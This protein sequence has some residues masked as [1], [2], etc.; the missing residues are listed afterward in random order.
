MLKDTREAHCDDAYIEIMRRSSFVLCP[1]GYGSSSYR[2]F[3]ALKMGR[4]PVVLSDAW[5]APIGPNWEACSIFVR[6]ANAEHIPDLL[7][8]LEKKAAAMGLAARRT[9]DEWFGP[10]VAFH[11]IVE[12]CLT[13]LKERRIPEGIARNG[14]QLM[15]ARRFIEKVSRAVS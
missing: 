8:G 15:R 10:N 9:W 6:E 1:R 13:L 5:I 11:R 2:L 12:W 14:V 4:V 7:E 3:E